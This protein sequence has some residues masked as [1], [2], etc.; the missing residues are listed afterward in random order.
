MALYYCEFCNRNIEI[1]KKIKKAVCTNCGHFLITHSLNQE[2]QQRRERTRVMYCSKCNREQYGVPLDVMRN[3][4]LM[5]IK[6][7]KVSFFFY[8][9]AIW[10]I[11]F[12]IGLIGA[13]P[14]SIE[15]YTT[16]ENY[17]ATLIILISFIGFIA[18]SF[19]I[20]IIKR[21]KIKKEIKKLD[22]YIDNLTS[23]GH[24]FLCSVCFEPII[25]NPQEKI[26]LAI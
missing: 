12:I 23:K 13:I 8:C 18:L 19:L 17:Y 14:Y 20:F 25:R 4:S 22:S 9:S 5:K 16:I 21:R 7:P 3:D 2:D 10:L 6:N 1:S 15:T 24:D 26:N 11:V